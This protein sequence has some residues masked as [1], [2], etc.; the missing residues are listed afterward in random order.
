M[1]V[2]CLLGLFRANREI[3]VYLGVWIIRLRI[4]LIIKLEFIFASAGTTVVFVG[5][6]R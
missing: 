5:T 4:T 1:P 2:T 3:Q 6:V